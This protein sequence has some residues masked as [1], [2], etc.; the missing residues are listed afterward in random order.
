MPATV[1]R[2]VRCRAID[3]GAAA[4]AIAIQIAGAVHRRIPV[5]VLTAQPYIAL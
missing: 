3:A 1:Q 2:V 4:S 5:Q